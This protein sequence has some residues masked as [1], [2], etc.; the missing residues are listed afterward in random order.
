[1]KT[2]SKAMLT[3]N[4]GGGQLTAYFRYTFFSVENKYVFSLLFVAL[5]RGTRESS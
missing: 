1:M 3:P 2:L 5:L 4:E